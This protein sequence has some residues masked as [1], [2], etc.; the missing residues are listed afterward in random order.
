M[1]A[2]RSAARHRGSF[3][4][5]L[6]RALRGQKLLKE[7]GFS[8]MSARPRH[9]AQDAWIVEEFKKLSAHAKRPPRGHGHR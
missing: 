4:R 8:H 3:R 2:H 6:S 7:L 5:R 1:A 9:P